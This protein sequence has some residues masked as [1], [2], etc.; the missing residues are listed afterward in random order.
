MTVKLALLKSG[1]DVIANFQEI[2][3]EEKVVG[4]LAKDP[5]IVRLNRADIPTEP[6][7]TK[8][9]L[10]FFPWMPLSKQ[11]DIPIDPNWLVTMVDPVDAVIDS[12]QEKLNVIQEKRKANSTNDGSASDSGD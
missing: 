9:A 1:E 11:T 12:Y 5:Y 10:S 8:V 4:Y 6:E 2:V 3:I 7:Q